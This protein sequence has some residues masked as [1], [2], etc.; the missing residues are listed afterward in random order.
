LQV[1][2]AEVRLEYWHEPHEGWHWPVMMA[3]VTI[4]I[5]PFVESKDR[6]RAVLLRSWIWM[7]S[8]NL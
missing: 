1:R 2:Q 7:V 5:A 3:K 6:V 8:V 4:D